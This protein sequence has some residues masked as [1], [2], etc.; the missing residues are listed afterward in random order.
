MSMLNKA[1][2]IKFAGQLEHLAE[3]FHFG[4]NLPRLT[5]SV[6][7]VQLSPVI[8]RELKGSDMAD[9]S[10]YVSLQAINIFLNDLRAAL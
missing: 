4:S 8:I 7:W 10:G 1:T 5:T 9:D 2:A 3:L 6:G